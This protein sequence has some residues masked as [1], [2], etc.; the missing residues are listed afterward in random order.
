MFSSENWELTH[1]WPNIKSSKHF[2]QLWVAFLQKQSWWESEQCVYKV[3]SH[4]PGK[5]L[6]WIVY[7][8]HHIKKIPAWIIL[9]VCD[10]RGQ[11]DCTG[12]VTGHHSTWCHPGQEWHWGWP[13]ACCPQV[14]LARW[15]G[16]PDSSIYLIILYSGNEKFGW[17]EYLILTSLFCKNE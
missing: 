4:F 16:A 14:M 9:H 8:K 17:G 12:W 7:I 3:S 15:P 6:W 5:W 2:C 11:N 10:V 13:A 1:S